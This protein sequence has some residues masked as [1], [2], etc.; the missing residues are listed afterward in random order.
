MQSRFSPSAG[1]TLLVAMLAAPAETVG[2]WRASSDAGSGLP[3][4]T[5]LAVSGALFLVSAIYRF[6]HRQKPPEDITPAFQADEMTC[7][8][9]PEDPDRA[10]FWRL[11]T[12]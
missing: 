8:Q 9:P 3:W 5:P 10:N 4:W 6:K 11:L 7:E 1:A 12:E 2:S